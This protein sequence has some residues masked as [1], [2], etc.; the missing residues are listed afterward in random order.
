MASGGTTISQGGG[1]A[2]RYAAA[3]YDLADENGWLDDTVEQAANLGRLIDE[4]ADFRRLLE[5][6]LIDVQ[7][8][9]SGRARRA[10]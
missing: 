1:L 4:N 10:L 2:D 7:A 9:Q 6:P 8:G 5:S 3:L